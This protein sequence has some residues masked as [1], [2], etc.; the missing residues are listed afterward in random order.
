MKE[1]LTEGREMT[2]EAQVTRGNWYRHCT[3]TSVCVCVC[4]CVC[5]RF[6]VLH[7]TRT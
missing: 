5:E 4:V 3:C 2:K 7:N 6:H 1:R